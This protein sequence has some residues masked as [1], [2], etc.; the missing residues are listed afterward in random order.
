MPLPQGVM[1]EKVVCKGQGT[2]PALT[3]QWFLVSQEKWQWAGDVGVKLETYPEAEKHHPKHSG[4]F[5]L[6][7]R[8]LASVTL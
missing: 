5:L 7:K 2:Q 4:S 3:P 1:W 6:A 8:H